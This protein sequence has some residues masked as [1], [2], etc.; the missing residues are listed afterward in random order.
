MIAQILNPKGCNPNDIQRTIHTENGI[1]RIVSK[2]PN[3]FFLTVE[4]DVD[5][6]FTIIPSGEIIDIGNGVFQ[7]PD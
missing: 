6:N 5:G 7:I 3:G 1:T 4:Q 2:Y